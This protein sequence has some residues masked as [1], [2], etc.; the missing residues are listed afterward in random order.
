ASV[1]AKISAP[2]HSARPTMSWAAPFAAV[3][4]SSGSMSAIGTVVRIMIP[5]AASTPSST[6]SGDHPISGRPTSSRKRRRVFAAGGG[7]G[8]GGGR[9]ARGGGGGGGGGGLLIAADP[10]RWGRSAARPARSPAPERAR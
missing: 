4:S 6:V 3:L 1:S 10:D 5:I 8:G 7:S 2:A 9:L